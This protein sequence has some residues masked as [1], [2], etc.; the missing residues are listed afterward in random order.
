[1]RGRET[2]RERRG[3]ELEK[4]AREQADHLMALEDQ[5]ANLSRELSTLRQTHSKLVYTYREVLE[6]R[7]DSE[8]DSPLR[9][10]EDLGAKTEKGIVIMKPAADRFIND[11]ISST[12]ELK[13]FHSSG[14]VSTTNSAGDESEITVE[15]EMREVEERECKVEEVQGGERQEKLL[16]KVEVEVE[17]DD[18]MEYKLRNNDCVLRAVR[19]ESG[20]RGE[21]GLRGQ[22]E[23]RCRPV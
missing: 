5:K 6:K 3:R 16:V 23:R 12:P 10:Q 13:Q 1:M 20:L 15:D 4:K 2:G 14:I 8:R 9:N 18:L 17:E 22:C 21:Y 19:P 11:I 7:K